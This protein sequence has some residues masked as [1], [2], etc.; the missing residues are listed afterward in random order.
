MPITDTERKAIFEALHKAVQKLK[1][2]IVLSD[3][4]KTDL[5]FQAIGN[6]VVPYGHD[7]K[8]VDGMYFAS[9]AKRKDSMAF[10]F[11]P[12]YMQPDI[13]KAIPN[14]KKYLK[15]KTCF[16]FKKATDINTT[17]MDLMLAEGVRVLKEAGQLN[18]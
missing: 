5:S 10:Y 7:K 4:N 12:L 11:F 17:E 6:K 3:V 8:L 9:V 15:G 16:H 14:L 2:L 13:E 1:P 18:A